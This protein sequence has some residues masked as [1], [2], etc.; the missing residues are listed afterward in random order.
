MN[1]HPEFIVPVP[2]PSGQT[3]FRARLSRFASADGA[4]ATCHGLKRSG[5]ECWDIRAD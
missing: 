1:A 5:I 2:L 4:K 3:M